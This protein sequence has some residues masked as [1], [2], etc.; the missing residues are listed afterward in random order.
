MRSPVSSAADDIDKHAVDPGG[1]A[2]QLLLFPPRHVKDRAGRLIDLAHRV[3]DQARNAA[4]SGR[5]M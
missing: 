2:S 5:L 4:T 1:M 3:L